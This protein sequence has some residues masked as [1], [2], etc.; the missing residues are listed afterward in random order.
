MVLLEILWNDLFPL[1][2]FIG[3]GWFLDSKF[4]LD[5]STYTKLTIYVVLPCFVFFSMY[6]YQ[7]TPADLVLLPAGLILLAL[8][9]VISQGISHSLQE[10][11]PSVPTFRRSPPFPMPAT[12]VPRWWSSSSATRPSPLAEKRPAWMKPWGTWLCS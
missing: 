2:V 3:C 12:S 8:S 9:Y 5:I 11:R 4:K 10:I 1:F 7:P 6:K